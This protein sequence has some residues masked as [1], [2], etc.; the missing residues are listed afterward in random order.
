MVRFGKSI[1]VFYPKDI[2][3]TCIVHGLHLIAEKIRANYCKV[4]K[5]IAN[6]IKK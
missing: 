3:V 4:D 2:Q 5:I 1:E 6:D